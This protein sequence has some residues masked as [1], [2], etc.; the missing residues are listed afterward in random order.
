[1]GTPQERAK[2][3]LGLVREHADASETQRHLK[4]E[5]ANAFAREGLFRIA[6]PIDFFGSE[7]DP[8]TQIETIETIASVDGSAAWNLMIGIETFG[9]IAPGFTHCRELIEDQSVIMCSSTASAGRA[10][11]VD[12]GYRVTGRWGFC[13]G[14]HN[15]DLF[16]AT[17]FIYENGEREESGHQYL[18]VPKAQFE[19]LDTWHTSGLCGSGSHDVLLEDV[20]VPEERLVAPL[21]KVQHQSALLR[22]PF[23]SR[24]CYN[25]VAIA[26]GLA[27][28]ALDSFVELAEGKVPRFTSKSLKNRG[29]AQRAIAESEVRVRSVRALVIELVESLWEKARLDQPVSD[30]EAAIFQLACSDAVRGCI[31]SVNQLVEA[32]GTTANQ[33]GHPLERTARDIRVVGQHQTVA[34]HHIEDAGRVLLGVPAVDAML[35]SMSS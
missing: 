19:I 10:E 5:V 21:G 1:M 24:L 4:S 2:S 29:W 13:S 25:K 32:A 26:F 7:Q 14:C 18:V 35:A 22:M 8:V 17:V 15:S 16:G 9:L 6:A 11:K 27:R 34:P 28:S 31:A 33:K 30:K 20:F 23:R 12:G 3:L